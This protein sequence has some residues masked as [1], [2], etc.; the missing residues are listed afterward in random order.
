VLGAIT[1]ELFRLVPG[2]DD[3][4]RRQRL[5]LLEACFGQPTMREVATLADDVLEAGLQR[6]LATGEGR[7]TTTKDRRAR[8]PGEEG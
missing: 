6:L 7:R 4:G 8:E 3:D 5:A 2:R 1:A